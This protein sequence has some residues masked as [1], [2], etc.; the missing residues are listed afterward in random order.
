VIKDR[1]GLIPVIFIQK[2][3]ILVAAKQCFWIRSIGT[4]SC[5]PLSTMPT[6]KIAS[7]VELSQL[8]TSSLD[9]IPSVLRRCWLGDRKGI[10]S[11][12]SHA[13]ASQGF[14]FGRPMEL[15]SETWDC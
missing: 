12:R 14:L 7:F 5:I 9:R 8:S 3:V 13:P 6:G 2:C 10:Q 15:S 11:V 1:S 4:R